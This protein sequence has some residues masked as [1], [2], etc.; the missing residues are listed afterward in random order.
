MT[1]YRPMAGLILVSVVFADGPAG[2][3]A[4]FTQAEKTAVL[5]AVYA[6][7]GI[8]RRLSEQWGNAQP[9]PVRRICTFTVT[10]GTRQLA[11][12]PWPKEPDW[13]KAKQHDQEWMDTATRKMGLEGPF[14]QRI[15]TL[16]DV[17]RT[18]A[19]GGRGVADA[20]PLFVT[21][22]H[23]HHQAFAPPEGYVVIDWPWLLATH[24]KML[25]EVVAHEIG[26]VFQAPDEYPGN[27]PNGL[28]HCLTTEV[29]GPYDTVNT[30]CATIIPATDDGVPAVL[31]LNQVPCLMNHGTP[32]LCPNTPL[33]WGWRD[34]DG[35]GIVDLVA[36]TTIELP[37]RIAVT[38]KEFTILGP[39]MWDVRAVS[40]GN[41]WAT[42]IVNNDATP[43][44]LDIVVP[45][46]VT[47]IV[48]INV[49]T[50]AGGCVSPWEDTW[51]YVGPEPPGPLPALGPLVLGLM[52]AAGAPGTRVRV[53][54]Y[55][56]GP[57]TQAVSFGSASADL[58]GLRV[59]DERPD[60]IEVPVPAH[61]TGGTVTVTVTTPRGVSPQFP[62][63]TE[64]TYQATP[65]G[66]GGGQ[67]GETGAA[68][69]V[70]EQA[71]GTRSRLVSAMDRLHDPS[72]DTRR[73]ALAEVL[74][75]P[76]LE[77]G[78]LLRSL[79]DLD[80][81]QAPERPALWTALTR[82]MAAAAE[83]ARP[84]W[85]LRVPGVVTAGPTG[86]TATG[87]TVPDPAELVFTL[88]ALRLAGA[89]DA[90]SVTLRLTLPTDPT[91]AAL[92]FT[93]DRLRVRLPA[94]GLLNLMVPGAAV[95]E[96]RVGAT[97]D[98]KGVRF[99]G[100]SSGGIDVPLSG[101]PHGVSAPSLNL[102]PLAAGDGIRLTASLGATLLGMAATLDG[103]GIEVSL[104]APGAAPSLRP[105]PPA[106]AGLVVALGPARGAGYLRERPDGRYG[107]AFVLR[108]GIVDVA[109]FGLL[110]ADPFSLLIV[111][112]AHFTPPIELGLAF[113]LNAIGGVVGV[114]YA[115]D[116][117]GLSAAVQSGHLDHLLFPADS[118]SAAPQ[119]V[120]T[121]AS[122][123]R[124][125][126]GG[127]LV[128]P[129]VRLGWGRPVSFLTA[130]LG[131]ILELHSGRTV[132]LGRLR[133]ALPA[134]QAPV[135]DLRAA[136][137][138]TIDAAGGRVQLDATLTG[139][140][141]ALFA[142]DGGLAMRVEAGD[143]PMF[144]LSAGG[145][146]DGFPVPADFPVPKRLTVPLADT[147][148]L[149]IIFR[150][151]VAITPGTLQIGAQLD[152]N[153]GTSST[154][155][156]GSLGFDALMRWE[157]SFGVS[158][159]AGGSFRLRI[160]GETLCSVSISVLVEGPTPCWHVAGRARV[161]IALA[162]VSFPFDESW[163][164]TG[165]ITAPA[166]PDVAS[167]LDKA[168][169]DPRSWA[170]LPPLG[171]EPIVVLDSRQ[172]GLLHPLGRVRFSQRVV[173]L[174]VPVTRFGPGRLPAATT[175]EVAVGF[176][177]GGPEHTKQTREQ[178]ARAD[179]F[180]LTDEQK[181]HEPAFEP[182]RSGAELVPPTPAALAMPRESRRMEYETKWVGDGLSLGTRLA[183]AAFVEAALANNAV[184]RSTIRD[185][186]RAL[187][188]P[189]REPI[190]LP[191]AY[192]TADTRTLTE[193]IT[194][195]RR[196][197]F[198][199]AAAQ[200]AG[201][202]QRDNLQLIPAHE[203]RR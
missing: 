91:A 152:V 6:G 65:T 167:L 73:A 174:G 158:L 63:F 125:R 81:G 66:M 199:E 201:A 31:N 45:P 192:A 64:F 186:D 147:P 105:V 29:R 54:G 67:P 26:H 193:D 39:G 180:D 58:T 130:D 27:F 9:V 146:R 94:G 137:K 46:G 35:D 153:V 114:N 77:P 200:L 132:I 23:C 194:R 149:R 101:V 61:P 17:L 122:V 121:L 134:P 140:R 102:A 95:L 191:R 92:S 154:G 28:P 203:V 120:A 55:R 99:T 166:P 8:L 25:N 163:A 133:M 11:L 2:S 15:R 145:F 88:P 141:L 4:G 106:G 150:G 84:D 157:P 195:P 47:G 89:L 90:D 189:E 87:T 181:L 71:A 5:R 100:G 10:H 7:T 79:T 56:L 97:A 24:S 184:A 108:M 165:Q 178:F 107:G 118:A 110:R 50:R 93:I 136:F 33:Y 124:E 42:T 179:F 103:T 113:T 49:F 131:V 164:C 159:R 83:Q 115:V 21:K 96:G 70:G 109:A 75:V 59:L 14:E 32:D 188:Q 52:P 3:S 197:T 183:D 123:F 57:V 53:L 143:H 127:A 51:V 40:V 116:D 177:A 43:E 86:V 168:V 76:G 85:S 111:L 37:E 48:S 69:P 160:A 151:Y 144:L 34:D 72:P 128:G 202:A 74:G 135:V 171:A 82:V 155:V 175:F 169:R 198:T 20:V 117:D 98:A 139:S 187:A 142:I 68:Q 138:G 126:R 62:P 41:V 182:L 196:Q 78:D 38:G 13:E 161:R 172:E 104:P 176:A 148:F 170:P 129:M 44:R 19:F 18:T 185:D 156:S 1:P 16:R 22:Y 162:T 60:E 112:S 30:N 36:P 12:P 80:T 190:L 173:P 119:V